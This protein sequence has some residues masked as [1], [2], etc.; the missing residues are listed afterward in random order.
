M[1]V[2]T[3]IYYI[4][5]QQIDS[6]KTTRLFLMNLMVIKATSINQSHERMHK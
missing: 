5:F 2:N 6:G 4:L 1:Y 3:S